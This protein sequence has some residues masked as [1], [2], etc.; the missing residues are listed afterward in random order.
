MAFAI[1]DIVYGKLLGKSNSNIEKIVNDNKNKVIK[2]AQEFSQKKAKHLLKKNN[3]APLLSFKNKHY[4]GAY[5]HDLLGEIMVRLNAKGHL[6]IEWGNM[7]SAVFSTETKDNV[8]VEFVPNA[9]ENLE[10]EVKN[11]K[12]ESLSYKG[13]R[14]IRA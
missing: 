14:F 3:S 1:E 4:S 2:R 8:K 10:F 5:R 11:K 12:I 13:F 6:E 7:H 9:K